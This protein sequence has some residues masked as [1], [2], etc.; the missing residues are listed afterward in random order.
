[1]SHFVGGLWIRVAYALIDV[2]CVAINCALAFSLRF[3][4][5]HV[6][7]LLLSGHWAVAGDQSLSHYA[8]FLLLYAV[9]ILLFCQWQDLYWTP[10]TRSAQ[11]E[12]TAVFKAVFLA[13]LLL[14]AFIFLSGVKIVSRLVVIVSLLLNTITLAA[15]RYAKRR[16]VIH[17]TERGIGTR[18]IVII[19]AGKVG[20]ALAR[21]LEEN[22]LLGYQLVGFLDGNHSN[23]PRLLGKIE[24]LSRVAKSEFVDEVF[25]TIPSERELVKRITAEAQQNRLAVKVIPDLYDG[26]AWNAPIRQ[27]GDFPVMDLCWK[28]LPTFGRFLKRAFDLGVS[29]IA[30]AVCAPLLAALAVW[31]KLDSLGPVIYRSRRAGRRG[32]VFTCFKLRTMVSDADAL[33]DSLRH[34]NEREGPCFKIADDP[35]VTRSGRFLRKYSL[36]ELPQLWNVIKGDMSLVGP[37]PHPIDDFE[38]YSLD[39]LRRLEVQPGITGLW[40]VSARQDPSFETNMALDLKY[41][42]HWRFSMDIRILLRTLP[43]IAKGQGQ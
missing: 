43:A 17:R 5:A 40:Q 18:N 34:R 16:I 26:L 12:T 25:V 32:R 7:R 42:E 2:I 9:L 41:I 31:V 28:P 37:R 33:K 4:P 1:V 6:R 21:H 14:T 22:K 27:I 13:T 3:S 15:W 10:R 23:E 39:D 20:Q 24:E 30:L 29:V 11:E 36:D 35:R 19:G 38:R 8:A